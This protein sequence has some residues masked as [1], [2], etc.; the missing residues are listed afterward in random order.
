ME[1]H[2]LGYLSRLP[3]F[4]YLEPRTLEEVC[5]ALSSYGEEAKILSGG[6]DLLVSMKKR[7]I[8]PRYVINLK[9]VPGLDYITYSTSD[10]LRIGALATLSNIESSKVV[11]ERFPL[12]AEA[13]YQTGPSHIR[14]M[15]T[16]VGNICNADAA[17]DSVPAL[18]ALGAKVKVQGL[19]T[20][21]TIPID[22]FIVDSKKT[23]L[24][25]DEIVIEVQVPDMP[26]NTC[27]VFIKIPERTMID[28]AVASAAVVV[29]ADEKGSKVVDSK[30]VF[31][32]VAPVPFRARI[33]ESMIRGKAVDTRLIERV[34]Q[35]ASEE[36]RP[37]TR[38]EYKRQLVATLVKR[39]FR[40]A[41]NLN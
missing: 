14:N 35:A 37:R 23:A 36:A 9:T 33:A 25:G 10:G 19:S 18:I 39:S 11:R 34:A 29:T 5:T 30:I 27:G 4:D 15:G 2:R 31:G 13:A 12:M 3:R 28:I 20:I 22:E 7:D 38:H 41:L 17:A 8:V 16:M 26:P 24:K 32:A 40:Q 1:E 21:R 6:T